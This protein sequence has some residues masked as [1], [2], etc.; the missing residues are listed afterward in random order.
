MPINAFRV[1]NPEDIREYELNR[2]KK[3]KIVWEI[4]IKSMKTF[5]TLK[6]T[7]LC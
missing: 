4:A 3:P 1:E 2:T 5:K 6:K 7:L